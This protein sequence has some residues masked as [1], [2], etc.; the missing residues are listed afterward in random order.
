V[1]EDEEEEDYDM[2]EAERRANERMQAGDGELSYDAAGW[3]G[4]G[5]EAC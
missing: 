1:Q 2:E 5:D 3:R 4:F